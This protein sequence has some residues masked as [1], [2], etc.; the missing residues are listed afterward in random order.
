MKTK[1]D[2]GIQSGPYKGTSWSHLW[3]DTI[4]SRTLAAHSFGQTQCEDPSGL[5]TLHICLI[6]VTREIKRH[7]GFV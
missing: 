7:E 5:Q 6:T 2:L 1:R 3:K 4:S